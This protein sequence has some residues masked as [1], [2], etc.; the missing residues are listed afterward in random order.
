V[1]DQLL[2][3]LARLGPSLPH[4][5]HILTRLR[6]LSALHAS[7]AEF[8]SAIG[9]LEQEQQKLDEALN[10]LEGAVETVEKNLEDNRGVVRGNVA[11]L[12]SRVEALLARLEELSRT[13][14]V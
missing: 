10:E 1:Q 9:T 6:T 3:L 4:I 14:P 13:A 7:A 8:Q 2:P 12:D 11:S 5:P